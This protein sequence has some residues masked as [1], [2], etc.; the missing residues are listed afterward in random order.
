M[1]KIVAFQRKEIRMWCDVAGM[2]VI[3]EGVDWSALGL[4]E[5]EIGEVVHLREEQ[6]DPCDKCGQFGGVWI[7]SDNATTHALHEF[8]CDKHLIVEVPNFLKEG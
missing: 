1:A 2:P 4:R 7:D 3:L 8:R 5:R 6:H